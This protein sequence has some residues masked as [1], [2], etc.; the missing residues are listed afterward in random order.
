VKQVHA[1]KPRST[2]ISAIPNLLVPA[3]RSLLPGS[4]SGNVETHF[5]AQEEAQEPQKVYPLI[6]A[7]RSAL[8]AYDRWSLLSRAY[9]AVARGTI[10]FCDRYPSLRSGATDSP[11]LTHLPLDP[12]RYPVRHLLARFEARFYRQIPPPD[13]IILLTVPVEV[14]VRRNQMR[15]K[16]E[17]EDYVR[18]RHAQSAN[19][20]FG[21][22]PVYRVNTD[23]PLERTVLEIKKAIWKAL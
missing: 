9:R 13:L 2:L 15:G 23:Q 18:R 3:L 8:L 4:R 14:A 22:T 10:V 12:Q 16:L 17:P 1:G 5:T 11:Q 6:F 20:D 7:L 19:L 21:E